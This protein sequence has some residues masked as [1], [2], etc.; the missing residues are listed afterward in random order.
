MA[1]LEIHL[2]GR[3]QGLFLMIF[4]AYRQELFSVRPNKQLTDPDRGRYL[5]STNGQKPGTPVV[6]L[7]KCWKK[8]RRRVTP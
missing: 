7:G 4:C 1:Q 2:K 5:H 8:L 3:L 6:E